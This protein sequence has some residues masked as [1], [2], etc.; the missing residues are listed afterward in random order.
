MDIL[1]DAMDSPANS[2]CL[3]H[4]VYSKFIGILVALLV[5]HRVITSLGPA[6]KAH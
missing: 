5:K 4:V 2:R 6:V 1:L 3:A